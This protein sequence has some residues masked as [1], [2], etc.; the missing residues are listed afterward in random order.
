[1][2]NC[3]SSVALKLNQT[4]EVVY[5]HFND[6]KLVGKQ[7]TNKMLNTEVK[8]SKTN[9]ED[10]MFK[11][12]REIIFYFVCSSYL[13]V[14]KDFYPVEFNKNILIKPV[15]VINSLI[16]AFDELPILFYPIKFWT[17]ISDKRR[18]QKVKKNEVGCHNW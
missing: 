2:E 14:Q 10:A 18:K 5:C 7:Q 12:R 9:L 17:K 16:P 13:K 3:K 4:S 8:V 1:M 6:R 15:K 11:G